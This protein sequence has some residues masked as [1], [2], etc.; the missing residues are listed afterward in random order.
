M[1]KYWSKKPPNIV[2]Y[3]IEKYSKVKDIV[4]DP[5]SG[6]G[7]TSIKALRLGRNEVLVDLNPVAI[8]ISNV[9]INPRK[10]R[11]GEII[12]SQ[13]LLGFHAIKIIQQS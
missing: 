4:L 9:M 3:F 12:P 13:K 10:I 7:V 5:F 11:K 1:R 8:F 6:Y 2:A